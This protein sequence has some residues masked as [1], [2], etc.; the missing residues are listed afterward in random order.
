MWDVRARAPVYELATGNNRAASL[1]WDSKQNSLYAA[2]DC[3]Y[4][5]QFGFRHGYRGGY[6]PDRPLPENEDEDDEYDGDYERCWPDSA[7]HTEA[8][9]G[10]TFDAGEHRVCAYFQF[11][12]GTEVLMSFDFQIVMRS[13]RILILLYCLR[14]GMLGWQKWT[15]FGSGWWRQSLVV[16]FLSVSEFWVCLLK[17]FMR[18]L[19]RCLDEARTSHLVQAVIQMPY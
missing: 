1:A 15:V 8:Y 16:L 13:R 7:F 3:I 11:S 9:F 17:D 14:M 5:D 18:H 12:D 19:H 4:M 10:Y 2:T 6:M